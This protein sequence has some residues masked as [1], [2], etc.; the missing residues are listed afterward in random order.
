MSADSYTA[1][2]TDAPLIEETIDSNF[3]ATVAAHPDREALV[4]RHQGVRWSYT[5][6]DA[7]IDRLARALGAPPHAQHA[8]LRGH[9][10][11]DQARTVNE[12]WE[13]VQDRKKAGATTTLGTL[14]TT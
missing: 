11:D 3:R 1:G 13:A 2:P 8:A 12:G 4:V 14:F 5:G 6:L 7:E 9:R 10:L